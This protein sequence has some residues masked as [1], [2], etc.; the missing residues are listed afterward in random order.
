MDFKEKLIC[1]RKQSGLSQENLGDK[2]GVTRQTVSKWELGETTPDMD[3]L[4]QLAELFGITIDELVGKEDCPQENGSLCMR[5]YTGHYEY[6]SKKCIGG[7]PL[8]HINVGTGTYKAKGII[9]IGNFSK[10][11]ISIGL[12]SIGLISLGVFSLGLLAFGA[13][14][15]GLILAAGAISAGAIAFG[16]IAVGIVACGGLAVG[17]YA[18]GGCA[19]ASKIAVGGYASA[20]IAIGDKTSGETVFNIHAAGQEQAIKEAILSKFPRTAKILVD[21]FS[22]VSAK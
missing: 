12:F 19:I 5:Q 7:V 4:I 11:I 3:K 8:I 22:K 14:T 10:G 2:I 21:I 20:A 6:K 17:M 15:L 18:L 13:M 9:A 1:L 16:G